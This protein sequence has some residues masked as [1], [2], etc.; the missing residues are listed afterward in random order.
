MGYTAE[1]F[2]LFSGSSYLHCLSLQLLWFKMLSDVLS[3]IE[4]SDLGFMAKLCSGW[5]TSIGLRARENLSSLCWI[6]N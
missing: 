4:L 3:F 1:S 2:E 6:G 5:L